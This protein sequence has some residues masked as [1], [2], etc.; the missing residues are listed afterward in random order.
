MLPQCAHTLLHQRELHYIDDAHLDCLHHVRLAAH[1]VLLM[2]QH[3]RHVV[4]HA[5]ETQ[6]QRRVDG[7]G[8][9]GGGMRG[10]S[11]GTLHAPVHA[12][13]VVPSLHGVISPLHGVEQ[14]LHLV[15]LHQRHVEL[16]RLWGGQ[17]GLQ[18]R[19]PLVQ[20]CHGKHFISNLLEHL[21]RRGV[22]PA[23][24]H[25]HQHLEP[26][27]KARA[28]GAKKLLAA[29]ASPHHGRDCRGPAVC[30]LSLRPSQ[31]VWRN[32]RGIACDTTAG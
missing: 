25:H 3:D 24:P 26:L 11:G 16:R 15:P 8:F 27:G 30:S 28:A 4:G 7:D 10:D 23:V 12:A 21:L 2:H 5:V 9:G 22:Q 18:D 14:R 13:V 1:V 29:G 31:T 17:S 20:R 6:A 32:A 19:Q